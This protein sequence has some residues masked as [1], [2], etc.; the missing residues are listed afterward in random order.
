MIFFRKKDKAE[1]VSARDLDK[2]REAEEQKKRKKK[3]EKTKRSVKKTVIDTMPYE[4]FVSNHVMLMRTGVRL[5][6]QIL[7][8]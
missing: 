6:R 5:G 4:R 7:N 3:K 8:L 2:A 1:K